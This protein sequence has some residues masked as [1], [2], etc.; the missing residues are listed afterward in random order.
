MEVSGPNTCKLSVLIIIIK[1]TSF[2]ASLFFRCLNKKQLCRSIQKKS[3][4]TLTPSLV[5]DPEMGFALFE[6]PLPT[7]ISGTERKLCGG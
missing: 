2:S 4:F 3:S 7:R 6:A 1:T 5:F